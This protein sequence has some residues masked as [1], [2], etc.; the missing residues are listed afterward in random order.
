[1]LSAGQISR[2]SAGRAL[3][4]PAPEIEH[5]LAL[6]NL[7]GGELVWTEALAVADLV[8]GDA[9]LI[10]LGLPAIRAAVNQYRND[11]S[12]KP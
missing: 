4:A 3:G 8:D 10:L 9:E 11:R 12:A 1:M 7:L 2:E 6:W 5:V